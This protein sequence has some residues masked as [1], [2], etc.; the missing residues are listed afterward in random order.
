M[1]QEAGEAVVAPE[2]PGA[3]DMPTDPSEAADPISLLPQDLRNRLQSVGARHHYVPRFLLNR[4]GFDEDG[5]R[6][7]YRYE[8]ESGKAQ[9]LSTADVAVVKDYNTLKSRSKEEAGL[10]ELFFALFEEQAAPI[11]STLVAGE[12]PSL[13]EMGILANFVAAQQVRTPRG[14][15]YARFMM[16]EARRLSMINE[17]ATGGERVK[18][19]LRESLG[20]EPSADEV[21]EWQADTIAVL[22]HDVKVVADREHEI[23]GQTIALE[24]LAE[25]VISKQ[26]VVLHS[27]PAKRFRFVLSDEPLVRRD[28][29]SQS[30]NAG[31]AST[32]FEATLPVDPEACLLFQ[33]GEA[34]S[35]V[36]MRCP[37]PKV[38]EVNLR[39]YAWAREALFGPNEDRIRE[40]VAQARRSPKLI[41][42]LRPV[43]PKIYIFEEPEPKSLEGATIIAGPSSTPIRKR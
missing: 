16:E 33:Q 25:T 40:V 31:W 29:A 21:S 13:K 30:G 26:L 22:E 17:V 8:L 7:I 37:A 36:H 11:I 39:T 24:K 3:P 42:A 43:A 35:V 41:A 27:P 23:V 38:E 34:A 20:R 5:H 4:F 19:H 15:G 28:P 6:R 14:R 12:E 1:R 9:S 10:F 32:S 18:D 2:M